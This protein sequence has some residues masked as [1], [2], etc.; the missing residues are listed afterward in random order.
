V[1]DRAAALVARRQVLG[2]GA[3]ERRAPAIGIDEM[4][5]GLLD[6]RFVIESTAA[7][8]MLLDEIKPL[9]G[10]R[11]LLGKA[12]PCVGRDRELGTLK[13]VLTECAEEPVARAVLVTAPAGVGKSR[14]A[15]E[16]LRAVKER[17]QQVEIWV[18]HA[19]VLSAGSAFAPLGHALRSACGIHDGEPLEERRHK[20]RERVARHVAAGEQQRVTEFLGE[21]VGAPFSDDESLPLRAARQDPQLMSDQ[22]RRAFIELVSAETSAQ[23]LLLVLEDLH[24]GDQPTGRVVGEALKSLKDRP[25]MV[26]ALARPEVNGAGG[27]RLHRVRFGAGRPPLLPCG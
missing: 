6:G 8:P 27:A 12:T 18:G 26:L 20:L 17:G 2:E 16:F 25:W 1:I 19:D 22:M 4:T 7:G 15:L 10:T 5:A 24:W 9:E 21:L 23:P 3:L 11:T 14:L 13:A